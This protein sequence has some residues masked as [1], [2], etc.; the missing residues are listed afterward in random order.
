MKKLSL[1]VILLFFPLIFLTAQIG[2][3]DPLIIINGKI[4][5]IKLSS[6]NPS[7][8]ESMSVS[9]SQA[10]KDAYGILSENGVISITTKNYVKTES[11]KDHPSGPLIFVDG[12]VY[13]SSLDSIII[14]EVESVTVIK[15]KSATVTYGKAGENGI[16]LITTKENTHTN[17]Q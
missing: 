6:L 11:S 8:I 9:K 7:D 2:K 14:Q 13:T 3:K 12:E 5:N 17:K 10:S 4:S 16:I 1:L 15:D